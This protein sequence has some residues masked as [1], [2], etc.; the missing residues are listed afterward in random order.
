[1]EH[2]GTKGAEFG[3]TTGRSRR[4]GWFD[5]VV[6]SHAVRTNGVTGVALTKLDVL[7]GLETLKICTSYTRNGEKVEHLPGDTSV[8][9]SCVPVYEEMP[10]WSESTVGCK[11]V[12]D[13]PKAARD[14]IA[15][16]EELVG[17][18]VAILSTGPD[19][20][21]TLVIDNP[22]DA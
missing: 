9:E 15:R 12:N 19:R 20:N 21:E 13:L 5:A 10:G 6:V 17:V 1:G 11:D 4:C 22:F 18:K 16:L 8:L 3:A 7:D 2:L 14:Y